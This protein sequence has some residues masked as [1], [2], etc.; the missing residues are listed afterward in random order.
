MEILKFNSKMTI[1][2]KQAKK[3]II[4]TG[5][6]PNKISHIADKHMKRYLL[7]NLKIGNWKPKAQWDWFFCKHK[8]G[9]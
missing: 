3:L 4:L 2:L 9:L 5:I 1:Q 6:C 8:E 7:E